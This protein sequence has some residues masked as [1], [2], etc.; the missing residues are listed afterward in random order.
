[1]NTRFGI[2]VWCIKASKSA[3]RFLPRAKRSSKRTALT[4]E[5]LP[6]KAATFP[7]SLSQMEPCARHFPALRIVTIGKTCA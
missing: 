7:E 5:N 2:F 3:E 6:N 4:Q 1:M